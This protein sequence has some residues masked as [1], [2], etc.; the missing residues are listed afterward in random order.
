[1]VGWHHQLNGHELDQALEDSAQGGLVCCS[2]WG[3]KESE[4]TYQLNKNQDRMLDESGRG[5]HTYSREGFPGQ[6]T[7]ERRIGRQ[8]VGQV[9]G[10]GDSLQ[11][12][13]Q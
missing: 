12:G 6:V 2:P 3:R 13:Q 10:R 11:R 7:S 9:Q 4:T 1:M 5:S 8:G